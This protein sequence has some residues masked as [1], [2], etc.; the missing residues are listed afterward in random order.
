M[1]SGPHDSYMSTI[2][3]KP[4][5]S[6]AKRRAHIPTSTEA[7]KTANHQRTATASSKRFLLSSL[8]G[9]NNTKSSIQF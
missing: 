4:K 9:H 7:P 6:I 5:T 2:S 3:Q 1:F 8:L